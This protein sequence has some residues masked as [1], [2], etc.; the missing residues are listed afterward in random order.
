MPTVFAANESTVTVNGKP[1]EGVVSLEYQRS[2]T[3]SNLYA[4]GSAQRIGMISGPAAV[5]GRLTV[6]STSPDLD[7]LDPEASFQVIANLKRGT[8]AMT[9]T[10]DECYLTDKSFALGVGDHGQAVYAFSATTIVEK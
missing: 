8:T 3:R 2:Q 5:E 6:A 1:V 10:I 9:V 4:L 7:G